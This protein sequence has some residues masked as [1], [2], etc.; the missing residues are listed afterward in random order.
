MGKKTNYCLK[1]FSGHD[2]KNIGRKQEG[3]YV[4]TCAIWMGNVYFKVWGYS[5][6]GNA[7]FWYIFKLSTPFKEKISDN[8]IDLYK[9]KLPTNFYVNVSTSPGG[10][11]NNAFILIFIT[12]P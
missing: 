11:T 5:L 4:K 6:P 9:L 7:K 10:V 8:F 1:Y 3:R 12:P 2:L